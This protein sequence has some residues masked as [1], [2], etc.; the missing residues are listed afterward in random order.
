MG[1]VKLYGVWV[2]GFLLHAVQLSLHLRTLEL[3][4]CYVQVDLSDL[5]TQVE[6]LLGDCTKAKRELKWQPR[7]TFDQLVKE[8]V[9]SDMALMS[10]NPLA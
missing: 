5:A 10:R 8:M 9:E 1:C 4:E 2:A 6:T 3:I 7:H